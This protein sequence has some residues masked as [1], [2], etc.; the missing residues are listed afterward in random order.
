MRAN[1]ERVT[2]LEWHHEG[3]PVQI[4]V[5]EHLDTKGVPAD[6]WIQNWNTEDVTLNFTPTERKEIYE[7]VEDYYRSKANSAD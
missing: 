4:Y 7:V 1:V 2:H 3:T 5:F 6:Q